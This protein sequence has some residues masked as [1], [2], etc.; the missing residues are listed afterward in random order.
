MAECLPQSPASFNDSTHTACTNVALAMWRALQL[1]RVLLCR[2]HFD[3]FCFL[4]L[5]SPW[6]V[7]PYSPAF[8]RPPTCLAPGCFSFDGR[9]PF[10]REGTR[11]SSAPGNFLCPAE[12]PVCG[13]V[14]NPGRWCLSNLFTSQKVILLS[15]RPDFW[16]DVFVPKDELDARGRL[17]WLVR[18]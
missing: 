9:P 11:R 2:G 10:V 6:P 15:P 16:V 18:V 3:G 1:L 13:A 7:A 12:C 5:E 14:P 8:G 4:C 17:A